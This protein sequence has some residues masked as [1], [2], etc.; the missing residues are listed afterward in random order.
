MT[1]AHPAEPWR[2]KMVEPIRTTTRAERESALRA[3][4]YNPCPLRAEDVYIDPFTDSGTNA[5]S[6]R[7]WSAMFRG[8][9]S[10]CGASSFYRLRDTVR[11]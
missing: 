3:A 11:A 1:A 6:D 2:I 4:A 8:D 5:L 7:Q 10:Y 9:E